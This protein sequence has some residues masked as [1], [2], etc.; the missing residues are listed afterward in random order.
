MKKLLLVLVMSTVAGTT[1]CKKE[2]PRQENYY[3]EGDV[4]L[5]KESNLPAGQ[6]PVVIVVMGDGFVQNDYAVGGFFDTKA[7]EML[8]GLF[9]VEPYKTYR[10]YFE[11][12]KLVLLSN[13]RGITVTAPRIDGT[14]VRTVDTRLKLSVDGDNSTIIHLDPEAI[15]REAVE[16]VGE[17]ELIRTAVIVLSNTTTTAGTCY[18]YDG[19]CC[20]AA[21]TLGDNH[22]ETNIHECGGHGIAKLGDEYENEPDAAISPDE[23]VAIEEIRNGMGGVWNYLGNIDLTGSYDAVHWKH[24]FNLSGYDVDLY[25]GGNYYGYGVWRGSYNTIMRYHWEDV[26]FNAP[27]REAI[28]RR[29]M[30]TAGVEFDFTE[31]L[32]KDVEAKPTTSPFGATP[33]VRYEW[34]HTP[35]VFMG[36]LPGGK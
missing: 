28:V 3:A 30:K 20:V 36:K 11:V 21:S 1:A 6:D 10:D 25:E 4:V 19:T 22:I 12:Y 15:L 13:E 35:P 14:P 8:E 24:Y 29:I 18:M 33:A 2:Q 5:W 31:F 17:S 26:W 9:A 32:A 7:D 34:A 23:A 16:V 27:S